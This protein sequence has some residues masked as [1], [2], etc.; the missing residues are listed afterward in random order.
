M[1]S[2]VKVMLHIM[3]I[4]VHKPQHIHGQALGRIKRDLKCTQQCAAGPN[5]LINGQRDQTLICYE[6]QQIGLTE[7]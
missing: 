7:A 4:A 6:I 3:P 1:D 2:S 5:L